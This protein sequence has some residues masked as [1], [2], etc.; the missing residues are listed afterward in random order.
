MKIL[1]IIAI[2]FLSSCAPVV[3]Q[4][5]VGNSKKFIYDKLHEKG[6]VIH[7]YAETEKMLNSF[8]VNDIYLSKMYIFNSNNLCVK[9]MLWLKDQTFS[10]METLLLNEGYIRHTDN[11]YYNDDYVAKI[12]Y[13][14]TDEEWLFVI[15]SK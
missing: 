13:N 1:L 8:F 5:Y 9:Y 3:A 6:Y 14:T 2:L 4:N 7:E 10:G 12:E 11:Y 15:V